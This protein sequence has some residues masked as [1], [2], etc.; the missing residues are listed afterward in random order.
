MNRTV[1]VD[2]L[3]SYTFGA[4]GVVGGLGAVGAVAVVEDV[5]GSGKARAAC[6]NA[7]LSR[8]KIGRTEFPYT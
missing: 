2:G 8:D 7:F 3:R 4:L 5:C 6:L 1:I